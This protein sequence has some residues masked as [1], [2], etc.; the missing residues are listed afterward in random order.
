MIYLHK[1]TNTWLATHSCLEYAGSAHTFIAPFAGRCAGGKKS[2]GSFAMEGKTSE[3]WTWMETESGP[4]CDNCLQTHA[5][6]TEH[7]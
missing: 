5:F 2:G 3:L 4:W 7:P 1:K 6:D